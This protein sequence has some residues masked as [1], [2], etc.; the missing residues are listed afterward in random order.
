MHEK[1]ML[2]DFMDNGTHKERKAVS[3]KIK[4]YLVYI[5]NT[6]WSTFKVYIR[7]VHG[8][9]IMSTHQKISQSQR[10]VNIYNLPTWNICGIRIYPFEW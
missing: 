5:K 8:R 6:V 10:M 3:S 4:Q 7:V 9:S 1:I 2:A